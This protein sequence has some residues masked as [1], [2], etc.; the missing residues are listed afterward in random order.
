MFNLKQLE[1][2]Y[3]AAKL[4]SFTA[5]AERLNYTQSTVS[6][7]IHD[8]EQNL[9]VSLFDRSQRTARITSKGRDLLKHAEELLNLSA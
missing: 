1:T 3:W 5:A 7:R 8:L 4:G 2:F 6:M 9:G